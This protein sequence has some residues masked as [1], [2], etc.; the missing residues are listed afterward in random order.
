[1]PPS[2]KNQRA[3]SNWAF[4]SRVKRDTDRINKL[5][6]EDKIRAFELRRT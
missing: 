4:I 2:K 1:M 3:M 5:L 6:K